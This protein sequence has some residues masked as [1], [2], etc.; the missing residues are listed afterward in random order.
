MT[1]TPSL[2]DGLTAIRTALRDDT[3]LA[4]LDWER[5]LGESAA[6]LERLA[7]ENE[8]LDKGW[9]EANVLDL[10]HQNSAGARIRELEAE[11]DAI[12]V[13][14]DS[15]VEMNAKLVNGADAIRA[16]TIEE[17]AKICDDAAEEEPEPVFPTVAARIRAL[18]QQNPNP[19]TE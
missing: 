6:A 9:H 1:D 12:R 4:E 19:E 14:Y 5:I 10:K 17:C 16:K 8:R 15:Q 18:N 7:R 3:P 11:R 13:A 2:I